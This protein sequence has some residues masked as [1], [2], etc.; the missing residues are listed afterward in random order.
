LEPMQELIDKATEIAND[1]G[2]KAPVDIALEL[3]E[4]LK[5]QEEKRVLDGSFEVEKIDLGYIPYKT[6]WKQ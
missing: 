3:V 1:S 6:N 2:C 4:E 5:A